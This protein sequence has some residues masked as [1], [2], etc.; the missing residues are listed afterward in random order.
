[1]EYVPEYKDMIY[2]GGVRPNTDI[3]LIYNKS[4]K[5][6][7]FLFELCDKKFKKFVDL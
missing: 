5:I 1:M 3:V 4:S 7:R 2:C 6:N